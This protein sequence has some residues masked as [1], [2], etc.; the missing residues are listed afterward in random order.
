MLGARMHSRLHLREAIWGLSGERGE[1]SD[2]AVCLEIG[3]V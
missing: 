2:R 1:S 3:T